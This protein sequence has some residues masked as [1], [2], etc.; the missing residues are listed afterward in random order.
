MSVEL[1]GIGGINQINNLKKNEQS[2]G[3][4]KTGETQTDKVEFSTV[5][6]DINKANVAA[7][8][9]NADRAERIEQ[10]RAQIAEG[11]YQPDPEKV[12]SS[13]LQFLLD[14]R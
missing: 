9:H 7:P 8:K 3:T 4:R 13:L 5:L 1:L 14:R 11:S 6:Q 2:A 10:L 12:A